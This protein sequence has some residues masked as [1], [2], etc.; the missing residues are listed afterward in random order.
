MNKNNLELNRRSFLGGAILLPGLATRVF[1]ATDGG[2]TPV[3]TTRTGKLR[4]RII[5]GVHTFKGIPYGAPTGGAN[6]FMPPQPPEPWT[7]I[8]DVFEY[9]HFAPQSNR[10]RGVKQLEYFG[11]LHPASTL[12]SSEDCLYLNVWTKGVNDGGKPPVMVWIHG[13]GY[14]QGSGGALGHDGAGL[15]NHQA[16]VTPHLNHPPHSLAY[17]SPPIAHPPHAP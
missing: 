4:G 5:D 8:R 9:G 13:G 16:V 17:S 11:I 10:A 15:A 12:G 3:V 7:G 2:S 6:R 1:A 14:D